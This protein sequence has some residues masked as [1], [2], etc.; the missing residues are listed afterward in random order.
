MIEIKYNE[1][2]LIKSKKEYYLNKPLAFDIE[3]TSTY[4]NGEK[5]SF[6]YCWALNIDDTEIVRGR[7]WEEFQ[8]IIKSWENY[9]FN[10]IIYVHNLP[11]EFQFLRKLFN[12]TD[13]FATDIRKVLK[14]K[15]SKNVILKDSLILS[16]MKLETLAKNLTKPMKKKVGDLDYTLVRTPLTPM[17]ETEWGYVDEDVNIV[18]EYIREQIEIYDN[19]TKIP[20][21]NTGRVRNYLKELCLY[22]GKKAH[23]RLSNY[24][25]E[26]KRLMSI[27]TLD[28]EEFRLL[29]EAFQGGFTHANYN[30]TNE[31]VSDVY[32]DDLTSSYPTVIVSEQFPMTKGQRFNQKTL[33][34][35]LEI[36]KHYLTVFTVRMTNVLSRIEFENY[37]SVSKVKGTNIVENNGRV[38]SADEITTSFTS[39]DLEI[40]LKCY[41]FDTFEVLGGY[42]YKQDYLPKSFLEGVLKL[43]KDKTELKGITGKE[44]EYLL[45][46]GMLNSTYGMMVTNF[47]KRDYIYSDDWAQDFSK[48]LE[49][50]I[51]T[52]N[53]SKS[54]FLFYAWGVFVTAYARRNVWSAILE[55]KD[56]YIYSDTDSVKY[57]NR[58]KHL[59]YFKRYNENIKN[60]LIKCLKYRNIPTDYLHPKN[61]HGDECWLGL[62]D[63][64]GKYEK[65]KTLGA[66]RYLVQKAGKFI[67]TCAG[68]S[69]KQGVEYLVNHGNPFEMF[70]DDMYIPK[71]H[72]GKMTHTY[73]D[74]YQ[75]H[76]VTDYLGQTT[77]VTSYSSIHLESCEFT[78]SLSEKYVDFIKTYVKGYIIL[79]EQREGV[80]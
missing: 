70:N 27:L 79:N 60:K 76:D 61:K 56:D 39:I 28:T 10:I 69:K 30:Y 18:V 16:G 53:T 51:E 77:H 23:K 74:E 68:L 3:T 46:K 65:F 64:E 44:R 73:I 42:A 48:T 63:Y 55:L 75:S 80:Y 7:T 58:E 2:D 43:Y 32:S 41:T 54:R 6:M 8:D 29:R 66:K 37:F 47:A 22:G 26:Y 4:V 71:E 35:I 52:E 62:W 12:I 14:C 13:V 36:N 72:T 57:V 11:Y 1:N 21:T 15:I 19:I 9:N 5:F 24:A 67:L 34:E 40:V 50:K 59:D 38:Y 49:D 31:V 25:R 20:L 78:L 45:S 17:T 33:Q